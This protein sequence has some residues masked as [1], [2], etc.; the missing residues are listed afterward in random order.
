MHSWAQGGSEQLVEDEVHV[1]GSSGEIIVIAPETQ[2]AQSE[3]GWIAY[4]VVGDG[5]VTLLVCK[6]TSFPIDLMWEE[7]AFA[8]FL[9]GLAS[10]SRSI[11]LDPLGTGAS[12]AAGE[13]EGRLGESHADSML[14]VLEAVGC[15]RAVVLG[16][17]PPALVFAATHPKRTDAL[18]LFNAV[19]RLRRDDDYPQGIP[20]HLVDRALANVAD[21]QGRIDLLLPA[22]SLA[23]NERFQSWLR[24]A[25]RLS[26]TPAHRLWRVRVTLESDMRAVLPAIR[27]P[28]LVLQRGGTPVG[29]AQRDYVAEHIPD[30]R[31]VRL[32]GDDELFFAG[33]P[34]PLLDA[35]E[36]FV[37]GKLPMHGVDRVLAT[38]M[39]TDVVGSSDH[40]TRSG[41]RRWREL[42]ATHDEVV[43]AE[44]ERFRGHEIRTL[45]DGFLA[46]FDGP[47]RALRCA[48]AI[49][50]AIQGLGIA[51]RIGLHTGEVEQ[52]DNDIAGIAV[53]IAQRVEATAQAG[54]VLASR[55]VV[56]LVAGSGITFTDRGTHQ[57]KGI[58]GDWRL[59]A[60]DA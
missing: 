46:T 14:A 59:Y 3:R 25:G 16:L 4:Q 9:T 28:T 27:V 47:G 19:A 29:Q 20:N 54:E 8:R 51:M 15:E 49:R 36:E 53:H 10:F 58:P 40:A 55:T 26:A 37:T 13:I 12:D 52:R 42:L 17:A 30:A 38:V 57:L 39:F 2:F 1:Y 6:H 22:P 5:P 48:N 32:P 44:L 7:P 50:Q 18:V 23:G 34:G 33:D 35:I 60:L 56:D 24:R 21:H 43:R 41:D 45:G 31:A 11:W